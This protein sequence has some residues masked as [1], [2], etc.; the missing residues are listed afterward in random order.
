MADNFKEVN[1]EA[2]ENT[3]EKEK[4]EVIAEKKPGKLE[5]AKYFGKKVVKSKP[6][7]IAVGAVVA[8]GGV[9]GVVLLTE[10]GLKAPDVSMDNIDKLLTDGTSVATNMPEIPNVINVVDEA[11]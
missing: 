3:E 6:F 1:N 11:V 4:T 10:L 7:K 2:T 8:I 5:K 9:V